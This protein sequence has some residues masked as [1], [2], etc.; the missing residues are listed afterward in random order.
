VPPRHL[1]WLTVR[2]CPGSLLILSLDPRPR[3]GRTLFQ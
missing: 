1:R 3:S 2:W